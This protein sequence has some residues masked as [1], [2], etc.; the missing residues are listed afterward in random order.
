[1]KATQKIVHSDTERIDIDLIRYIARDEEEAL[2]RLQSDTKKLA[3]TTVLRILRCP[4]EFLILTMGLLAL[5]CS[6]GPPTQ[7]ARSAPLDVA[8]AALS[9]DVALAPHQGKAPLDDEIAALQRK[10]RQENAPRGSLE[11]LGWLFVSKAR[12][13]FDTGYYKLAEQSAF[14]LLAQDPKSPSAALLRGHILHN[15]HRFKEAEVL[16]RD[17]V[18][19]RG[20]SFD[21]GLLGDVLMEQGNLSEAAEAYQ[22]MVDIRPDLRAYSRAAHVRWL[23]G[24]LEGA[25]DLLSM[26]TRTGSFRDPEPI[27]WAYSR[28]AIYELQAGLEW[29]AL[30]SSDRALELLPNYAPALLSRGRVHLARSNFSEATKDLAR[31]AE[32]N[33]LPEYR[34]A[35]SEALSSLG[36]EAQALEVEKILRSSGVREDPRTLSL[37]LSTRNTDPDLAVRLAREEMKTR[38]DILTLDALAW[39][40]QAAGRI[41]ESYSAMKAALAEKTEDARFHLHA[42]VIAARASQSRE[43]AIWLEK[44][45]QIRQMLLPSEQKL[46]TTWLARLDVV[47]KSEAPL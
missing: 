14:C 11:R 16:A 4:A 17:L 41:E 26:A 40:L 30:R 31:A 6:D 12:R 21:Y 47:N 23:K 22:E 33:P 45:G 28:L 19:T 43:A 8:L 2:V 15:L 1:M 27:A 32:L 20:L 13:A 5:G 10:I 37:Y 44:A 39:S 7:P 38:Q 42:G 36:R 24:D 18:A 29:E 3:Y 25:T 46:L 9:C 34:W 35:L